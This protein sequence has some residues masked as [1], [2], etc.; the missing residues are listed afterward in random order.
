MEVLSIKQN[1]TKNII[2]V[3]K[4][5][6]KTLRITY[7]VEGIILLLALFS[8][9][10]FSRFTQGLDLVPTI[11]ILFTINFIA[12]LIVFSLQ[13]SKDHGNLLF[14]T[15]INGMQFI[16]GHFLELLSVDFLILLIIGLVGSINAHSFASLL[17]TSSIGILLGLLSAHLIISAAIA[18]VSSYIRS[19]G[20][21]V[22]IVILICIIG[23]GVYG[24]LNRSIISFLP[25]FYMS[26]GRLGF[27]EIDLFSVLIDIIALIGLQIAAAYMIDKKLDIY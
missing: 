3:A 8:N 14:L 4:H 17:I 27:I 7:I 21:C 5:T 24:W 22:F 18:I 23:E 11:S 26:I 10:F 1:S 12:H 9:S 19:T 6:F 15:P 2:S 20:L 13:I 16:L 25:Y